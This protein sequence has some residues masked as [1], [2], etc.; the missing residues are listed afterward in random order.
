MKEKLNQM[1]KAFNQTKFGN[2]LNKT[3]EPI[4]MI[5]I[6][7]PNRLKLAKILGIL[8]AIMFF[9]FIA[10]GIISPRETVSNRTTEV[11]LLL[12]PYKTIGLFLGIIFII[13]F[14]AAVILFGIEIS[15]KRKES[16]Q[17]E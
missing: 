5:K 4:E 13:V 7:Y 6:T 8:S 9:V 1:K 12:E 10:L 15:Y 16:I 14:M 17:E 11:F 3:D 2:W